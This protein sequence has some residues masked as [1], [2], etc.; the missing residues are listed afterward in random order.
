MTQAIGYSEEMKNARLEFERKVTILT[1]R[2]TCTSCSRRRTRLI[3]VP[4]EIGMVAEF[5]TCM[6][7]N[8]L[9]AQTFVRLTWA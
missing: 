3:V 5:S 2:A 1:S 4:S 6:S 9:D 8:T 7:A